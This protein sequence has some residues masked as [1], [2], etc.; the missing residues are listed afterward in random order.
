MLKE[1][2]MLDEKS[3]LNAKNTGLSVIDI[4]AD[5]EPDKSLFDDK[6]NILNVET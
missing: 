6:V 5:S 4:D 3:K 2:P 1:H